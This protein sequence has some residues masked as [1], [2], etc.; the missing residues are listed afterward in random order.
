MYNLS[1]GLPVKDI[2]PKFGKL[3]ILF[4]GELTINGQFK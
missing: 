3:C 2:N 4:V 1:E